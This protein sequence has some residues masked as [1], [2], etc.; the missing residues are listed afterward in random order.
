LRARRGAAAR[1]HSREDLPAITHA[2]LPDRF[3]LLQVTPRLDAG[4]V[5][6]VTL[7]MAAATAAAGARS[8]VASRGGVLASRLAEAGARLVPLPVDSKS[9]L[10]IIANAGRLAGVIRRREISLV[11]VRSRA[12]AFSA[13]MAGRMTRTPVVATYHGIYSAR[14]GLKRWYNAVMTRGAATIANSQFTRRHLLAQ[15]EI[16]E[17]RVVVIPEGVDT[18]VFDPRAVS[19]DRI[20][21]VRAA[22]GL[23]PLDPRPVVLQA[24]RLTP[25]KGQQVAI[26]AFAALASRDAVLVLS[27][28]AQTPAFAE[29][30]AAAAR[31]AGLAERVRIVGA[32]ADMPAA[33]LAADLVIAPSTEAESFGRSVAEAC[34]MERLVIA[35]PLGAVTEILGEGDAGWLAAAGDAA[36]WSAAIDAALALG[37]DARRAIGRAARARVEAHYSLAVMCAA[38]FDLYRRL[39]EDRR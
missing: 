8:F 12:P 19:P 15:H 28:R 39:A 29:A 16:D 18:R 4:G 14:S 7:E 32:T 38:T 9:P 5:E 33:Y 31:A 3:A 10:T 25:W 23:R 6:A 21:A 13:L 30:L 22:W 11:H 35:S 17:R 37:E 34:A 2:S 27:G 20:Q 36:A 26:E 24:A 1:A